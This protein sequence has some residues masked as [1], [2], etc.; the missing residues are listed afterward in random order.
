MLIVVYVNI[1]IINQFLLYIKNCNL[2]GMTNN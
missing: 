2:L 1:V